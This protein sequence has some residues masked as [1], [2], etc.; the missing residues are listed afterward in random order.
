MLKYDITLL[1]NKI[2]T[3]ILTKFIRKLWEHI[4]SVKLTFI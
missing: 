4:S 3:K 1:Y 2:N